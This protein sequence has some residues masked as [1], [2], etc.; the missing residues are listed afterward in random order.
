MKLRVLLVLLFVT[1]VAAACETP[2]ELRNTSFLNDTSLVDNTPCQAPCWRGI[3]PGV[4]TWGE[5]LTILEDDATLADVKVE[6]NEETGEIAATFQRRDGVPC[7]LVYTRNGQV[8]D[9]MLL[10]LAPDK[11]LG[12]VIANLGEPAYFSGTEVS[13]EQAAAALFYPDLDL[14]VYAFVAGVESGQ[15]QAS[16]EIFAA[17]YLSDSDMKQV[18]ETSNLYAWE[19]YS[20]YASY[21]GRD[22]DVTPLPTV[23]GGT[24]A[25]TAEGTLA[26]I[27]EATQ[28]A[29]VEP[30]LESTAA[31][32]ETSTATEDATPEPT[33]EATATES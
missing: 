25:P 9:Q 27:I 1:V 4:T 13:P 32:E 2:P 30:T 18:I 21:T 29:T 17:L 3:T 11:T 8:V 6:S 14:V 12:E 31:S 23:E 24:L 22:F 26:D 5:A 10:Q 16:S 33:L 19:G 20:T 7:C 28:D 15:V